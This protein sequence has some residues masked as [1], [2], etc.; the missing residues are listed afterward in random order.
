MNQTVPTTEINLTRKIDARPEE[1]YKVWL[2]QT[3]PASPWYGVPK[4]ILYPAEVDSLFYSMYQIEGREIA[5]YG[6]FLTLE[7]P[8]KIQY[9]WVS[10]ATHG[11]ESIVTVSL[12]PLEEKTQVDLCHTNVPDDEGGHNHKRAWG[13]VLGRMSSYF[14]K[15]KPN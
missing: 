10:E 1:V 8:H 7:K 14:V 13:F 4:V 2:D 6:R 9:T 12:T 15:N 11:M 3:S 5:H